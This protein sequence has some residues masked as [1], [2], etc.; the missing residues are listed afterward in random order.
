MTILASEL[1]Q[2][3]RRRFGGPPR[4]GARAPGRVNLIGEHTD[5]NE[6][7]VLPC[8][9]DR[10]TVVWAAPRSDRRVRVFSRELGE[11]GFD[12]DRLA[13]RGDWLD[14]VRGAWF[15]LRERRI[16][17]GG[18]DLA[19][20]S[21][22][23]VG[24]G[25][26][27][28]A[29]LELAL[30]TALDACCGP[31]LAARERADLAHRAESGFVGVPC[32]IMDPWASGLG[33][34]GHGLRIDCR[35]RRVRLVPFPADRAR[36]LVAHSGAAREL[37]AGAYAERR[38]ECVRALEAA[39]GAGLVPTGGA[40][41]DLEPADLPTLERALDATA[42]RRARHVVTENARV[43]ALCRALADGDLDG[44]GRTLRQGMESLQRDFEVSTP[45]L[46]ALCELADAQPGVFGS[47]LTGAGFGGCTLHLV[48]PA[49]GSA[50][51]EAL[52][53]GFARRFGRRPPVWEVHPADGASRLTLPA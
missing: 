14:Y 1:R 24:S 39:Q 35:S 8:A 32:G 29:A 13:R 33:R 18:F 42:F 22:V 9:V 27:S 17:P 16:D 10:D 3:F 23:P 20:A 49:Q 37:A 28:S 53:A 26:S 46:D 4:A 52:A 41:R 51:A 40:L 21:D 36:L 48:A 38:A 25:L 43:D 6:G 45:E 12:A 11:G 34:A 44:A 31:G 7:L 19:L 15:A 2:E 50:V 5:Y 30:V 47:R